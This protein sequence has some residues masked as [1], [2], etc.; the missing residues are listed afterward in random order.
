MY[1]DYYSYLDEQTTFTH[2]PMI[3]RKSIDILNKKFK[4]EREEAA[5]VKQNKENKKHHFNYKGVL[6][7]DIEFSPSPKKKLTESVE[8]L[9][10]INK[11]KKSRND[12]FRVPESKSF[13]PKALG[14]KDCSKHRGGQV[15]TDIYSSFT[16]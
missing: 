8:K 7:G 13:Q 4:R 14:R 16:K 11:P 10:A 5:K 15:I 6:N 3:N 2:S 1:L 12:N 9:E